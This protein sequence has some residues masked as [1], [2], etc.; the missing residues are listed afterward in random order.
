MMT[1][2]QKSDVRGGCPARW[3]A[4]RNATNARAGLL[5]DGIVDTLVSY[6]LD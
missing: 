2:C 4:L 3:A 1:P 6:R 5:D